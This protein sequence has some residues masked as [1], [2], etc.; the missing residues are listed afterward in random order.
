MTYPPATPASMRLLA[1]LLADWGV[2]LRVVDG[3]LRIR[4]PD[5][6]LTE[7]DRAAVRHYSAELVDVLTT[8]DE[9]AATERDLEPALDPTRCP[10][11]CADL[12]AVGVAYR[13]DHRGDLFERCVA[14]GETWPWGEPRVTKPP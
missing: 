11:C 1:G 7:A 9:P 14:C 13:T 3:E 12:D 5:G 4:D 2:G 10:R 6:R 8:P